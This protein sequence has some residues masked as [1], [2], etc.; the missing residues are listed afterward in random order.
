MRI[1]P[2]HRFQ[3]DHAFNAFNPLVPEGLTVLSR[4]N[5]LK[6]SLAGLGGLSVPGLLKHQAQAAQSGKSSTNGRSVILLWM[7]GGPSH[8]DTWDPKPQ[9]PVNN[10]GP[11]APIQTALPG[12]YICE[13]LPKQAAMMD[14]FTLIRSVDPRKSSHQPNQVMQTG[15]LEAAPRSNPKGDRYPA[16]ASVCSK[17]RGANDPTMPPYV[18]FYRHDSHVAWAGYLGR[19]YDPFNGNDAARLP[20]YSLTGQKTG[21][22]SGGNL[23]SLA[24]G[25]NHERILERRSLQQQFDRLRT[26]LDRNGSMEALDTYG[27]QAVEMVVGGKAQ[28]AFD[29]SQESDSVRARYGD[30]LWCQQALLARRLV[31]S[32]VSFVTLDLSYH[33]ASGTWDNHGIPGGVYGGISKGLQPLLPLFDHLLTTLVSDLEERGLLENT[34]VIAMG[35]FGRTPNMGT[36]GSTDGRN[37][38]PVVMSMCMAGGG[39]NH[40]QVIGASTPDGANILERPVTPGDLAATIYRYMGVP[41]DGTYLDDR[42]RPRFIVEDGAPMPELFG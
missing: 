13:H 14:K 7:T 9:R 11:F 5:M 4:R 26:N 20:V 12:T 15:N 18:A 21:G 8:I 30:H 33:T 37:H 6:A 24:G 36:Q 10:R 16:I 2:G 17:F 32:G 3:H 34:L 40:S 29:L 23:F 41:V 22:M 31:E 35:E 1:P 39:L 19:E 28:R 42:Q 27:Q 38:W 25:L